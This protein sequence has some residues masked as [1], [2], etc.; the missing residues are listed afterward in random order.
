M[1]Q[2]TPLIHRA[3]TSYTIEDLKPESQYEVGMLLVPFPGQTTELQSQ[4]PVHIS[5]TMENGE[6][7]LHHI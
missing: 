1:Y 5:T 2:A 6:F 4:K 3:V 7:L